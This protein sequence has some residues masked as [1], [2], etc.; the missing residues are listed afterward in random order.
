[1]RVKYWLVCPKSCQIFEI[2]VMDKNSTRARESSDGDEVEP[3]TCLNKVLE[4]TMNSLRL[5][6]DMLLNRRQH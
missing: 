5:K 4:I 3:G 1:M 2:I 6:A